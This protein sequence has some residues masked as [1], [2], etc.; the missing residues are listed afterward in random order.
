MV[1]SIS[2][3]ADS[4]VSNR[5]SVLSSVPLLEEDSDTG[6]ETI[7]LEAAPLRKPPARHGIRGAP[8]PRIAASRNH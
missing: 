5:G 6:P 2:L 3:W 8:R 7:P 4:I 1:I